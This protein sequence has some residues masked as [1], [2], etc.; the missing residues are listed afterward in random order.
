MIA[1]A[2]T[3]KEDTLMDS[4]AAELDRRIFDRIDMPELEFGVAPAG[5]FAGLAGLEQLLRIPSGELPAPPMARTMRQWLSVIE[6]G[7]VEFRGEP[8]EEFLNPMGI[9]HGGWTMTLLDSALG[10]AVHT[11]LKPGEVY[12]SLGTE[13]KFIRPIQTTTGQVRAVAEVV[14]RG[15]RTATASARVEDQRGRILA[16]GATTCFI[17]S[18]K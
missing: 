13:V 14:T 12:S 8:S 9:I 5:R 10:C 6:K 1:R 16:T 18:L 3:L 7:K 11:M 17:Q 15:Q 4:E 2:A